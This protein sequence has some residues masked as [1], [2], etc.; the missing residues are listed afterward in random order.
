MKIAMRQVG[1]TLV[2]LTVAMAITGIVAVPLTGI[3]S[4]QLSVP[5]KIS[6]QVITDQQ[7]LKSSGIFAADGSRAQSFT[8]GEEPPVYGTFLWVELA[9]Q[10]PVEVTAR[11]V[12][13]KGEA[14]VF[15]EVVRGGMVVPPQAVIKGIKEFDDVTFHYD[16]P[17]WLFN[18]DAET[19]S[20]SEGK[21]EITITQTREAIVTFEHLVVD[22]RPKLDL[23]SPPPSR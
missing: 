10:S 15:R 8:P 3:M 11:Y 14:A 5:G 4:Q 19:W 20:Y 1:N 23:P 9:G 22:F 7:D 18:G 17:L 6:R 21:M 2:E 16:P 12:W 13:K